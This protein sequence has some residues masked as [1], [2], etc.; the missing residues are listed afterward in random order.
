[1]A[2]NADCEMDASVARIGS[3]RRH[4]LPLFSLLATGFLL[5]GGGMPAVAAPSQ[6]DVFRS[7]QTNVGGGTVD[8][9][10]SLP[11]LMAVIGFVL[12]LIVA[13]QRRKRVVV[14]KALNHQG[15][16]LREV[17]KAVPL[18]AKEVKQLKVLAE[19]ADADEPLASPLTLLLC[20]SLMART[21]QSKRLKVDRRALASVARKAGLQVTRK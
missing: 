4:F 5:L 20:P 19:N 3:D 6:E 18:R 21:I 17:L 7:I 9:S 16:L 14:P 1:M 11:I 2:T 8:S 15:K 13:S 12:L 10:K